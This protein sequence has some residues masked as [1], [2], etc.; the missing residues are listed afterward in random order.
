MLTI[1]ELL[2][3]LAELLLK[4][5]G[6]PCGL[7]QNAVEAMVANYSLI[8]T[9]I[10]PPFRTIPGHYGRSSSSRT[11]DPQSVCLLASSF[12]QP[13]AALRDF[14]PWLSVEVRDVQL[15]LQ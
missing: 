7:R 11:H 5:D 14:G 1:A 2:V 4:F 15:P 8:T 10:Q 13:A 12:A 3:Q 9:A 6:V